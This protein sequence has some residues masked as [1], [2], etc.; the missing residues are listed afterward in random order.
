M[1]NTLL[2]QGILF[3]N[4]M[5]KGGFQLTQ[6]VGASQEAENNSDIGEEEFFNDTDEG[7]V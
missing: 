3:Q 6:S 4:K 5:Q 2:A 7:I 1:K